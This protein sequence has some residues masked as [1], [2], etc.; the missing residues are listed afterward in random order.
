MTSKITPITAMRGIEINP[1]VEIAFQTL[2]SKDEV[3]KAL[4]STVLR[5]SVDVPVRSV[6]VQEQQE[7]LSFGNREEPRVGLVTARA[8]LADEERLSVQLQVS[9]KFR[10]LED[11]MGEFLS[12]LKKSESLFGF[13]KYVGVYFVDYEVFEDADVH[14]VFR[15][16]PAGDAVVPA[17]LEVHFVELTK[18]SE[19]SALK[20]RGVENWAL[21]LKSQDM[22][23]IGELVQLEPQI[24]D[25]VYYL[26]DMRRD[27]KFLAS[28]E[29]ATGQWLEREM[30]LAKARTDV[31]RDMARRMVTIG[32]PSDVIAALTGL[33]EAE[34]AALAAET[35]TSAESSES[36]T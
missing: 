18:V 33:S 2:F 7:K 30:E 6:Y 15:F 31:V 11:W 3:L 25:A 34:I 13:G 24:L 28:Y 32:Q 16:Q 27:R 22:R 26:Q 20:R 23:V 36:R 12:H 35:E 10:D 9:H 17:F 19:R 8:T 4:L 29:E 5:D 1:A 21:F 14:H